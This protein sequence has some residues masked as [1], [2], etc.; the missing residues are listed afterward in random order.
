MP[1]QKSIPAL[2]EEILDLNRRLGEKHLE[3][4]FEP[5]AS[6]IEIDVVERALGFPLPEDLRASFRTHSVVYTPWIGEIA[7]AFGLLPNIAEVIRDVNELLGPAPV[8]K[9]WPGTKTPVFGLGVI[10]LSSD[11]PLLGYDLDPGEG[12]TVGQIVELSLEFGDY[13]V[14]A[15]SLTAFLEQGIACLKRQL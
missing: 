10:P 4:Q 14:L 11:D 1:T 12:G 5:G 9:L 3:Q 15:P 13:K 8:L 6:D 7:P 2:W